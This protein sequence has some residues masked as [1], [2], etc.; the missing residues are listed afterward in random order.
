MLLAAGDKASRVGLASSTSPSRAFTPAMVACV[1]DADDSGH[2]ALLTQAEA[3]FKEAQGDG[4]GLTYSK[5][6]A[7]RG[8]LR[9]APQ[10]LRG[11]RHWRRG[12]RG[13]AFDLTATRT[14]T[15]MVWALRSRTPF[16]ASTTCSRPSCGAARGVFEPVIFLVRPAPGPPAAGPRWSSGSFVPQTHHHGLS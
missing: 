11:P 16:T 4:E 15:R 14:L 8:P 13:G 3:C 7:L 2:E 10:H 12:A 9:R 1:K 6:A 5:F